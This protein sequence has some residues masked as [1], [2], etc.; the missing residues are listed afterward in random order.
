MHAATAYTTFTFPSLYESLLGS[1]CFYWDLI[2]VAA[3]EI[4]AKYG[5][6]MIIPPYIWILITKCLETVANPSGEEMISR[7]ASR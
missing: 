7:R 6:S 3:R 4:F 2:R 1:Y 5:H